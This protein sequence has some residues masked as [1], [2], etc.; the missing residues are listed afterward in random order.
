M[1]RLNERKEP[2]HNIETEKF[3][4]IDTLYLSLSQHTGTFSKSTVSLNQKV[5]ESQL[6]AEASGY[7]SSNLHSPVSGIIEKI[8]YF[9]H[10][11]LKKNETIIIRNLNEPKKYS[12]INDVDRFSKEILLEKIKSAGTVGLGGAVFPTHV[13]LNPPKKI[14]TLII[15]GCECEPYLACDYRLMVEKSKEIFKGIEIVAKILEPKAIYLGIEE[16]KLEAIKKFNLIISTKKFNLPNVEIKVLKSSYPQGGEKQLIYS[17]TKRKVPIGKLPFDVGCVVFN[18]A[19]VFAIFEA[20]YYNKPLIERIVTFAGKALKKPKNLWIKIGTT[21]RE[22]FDKKVLEFCCEPT[23][24]IF[25]G[26]MMGIAIDSLDY[27]ILK[28]TGGV[29]FLTDKE[30]DLRDE[31]NCIRC[32]RCVDIC[33][34][35]LLPLEFVKHIKENF[36]SELNEFYIMD[37]IEC[38]C[39]AYNCPAKIPIVNY[40]KL[41]KQILKDLKNET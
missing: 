19:T 23:K 39:C 26:P 24:I 27:P 5:E 2:Q 40:I 21:L 35:G 22:L 4:D 28:G 11:I 32:A 16:N 17:I 3:I 12:Y 37:C 41:G 6:I 38:G 25:G 15:N 7:I 30:I 18:V 33:P 36:Y 10:P 29:L 1:I 13:K 9:N 20:I 14:D 8:T 34:M 31:T